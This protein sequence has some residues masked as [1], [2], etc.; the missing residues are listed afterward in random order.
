[1]DKLFDNLDFTRALDVYM[2]TLSGVSM[3]SFRK[4]ICDIGV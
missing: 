3:W 4:G 2:N 1:M